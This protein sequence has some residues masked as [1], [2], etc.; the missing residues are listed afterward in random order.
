MKDL[1]MAVEEASNGASHYKRVLSWSVVS[2]YS[3]ALPD[4]E[5]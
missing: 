5:L 2:N 4:A 1:P 3:K